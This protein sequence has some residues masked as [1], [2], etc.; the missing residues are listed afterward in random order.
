MPVTLTLEA[1]ESL[2]R[3]ALIA[4]GTSEGNAAAVANSIA[5]AEADGIRTVGLGFLPIYCRH[6]KVGKVD[7]KASAKWHAPAPGVLEVDAYH[8]FCHAAYKAAEADYIRM[9]RHQGIAIMTLNRSY[10]AGVLGWF[11]ESLANHGLLAL[12]FANA[13]PA[14]AP[15]GGTKPFFG[16]NPLAFA[17]PRTGRTALVIDQSSSTTAMVNVIDAARHDRS[18]PADWALDENGVPTTDPARGLAGSMAAAG[19][20]KGVSLALMVDI[21]AALGGAQFSYQASSLID[22]SGGPP[23][24]GQSFI[25]LDPDVFNIA[26]RLEPLLTVMIS[27]PGV[28]LPGDRRIACRDRA[29]SDGVSVDDE[30]FLE[31]ESYGGR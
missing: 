15:Y 22:D 29:A 19:G 21:L 4:C 3:N 11:V 28:R 23:N 25:A 31:I 1:V 16:T 14:I 6:L 10:T 20:Y 12:G 30:L 18:I 8:G 27:Q 24:V 5:A 9:V 7:G 2:A 17:I 13:S 26:D